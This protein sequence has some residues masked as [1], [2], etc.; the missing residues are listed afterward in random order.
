[1]NREVDSGHTEKH[2]FSRPTCREPNTL[3]V[4]LTRTKHNILGQQ[5]RCHV[6]LLAKK[7]KL[8]IGYLLL[9]L[10]CAG[11][12]IPPVDVSWECFT[13]IRRDE[14]PVG[15]KQSKEEMQPNDTRWVNP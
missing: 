14:L 2:Y 12:L 7:G 15:K 11:S 5:T 10:Q 13:K 6:S 4:S 9:L 1:M 8:L 3:A